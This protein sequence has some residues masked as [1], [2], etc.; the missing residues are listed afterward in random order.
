MENQVLNILT[1]IRPVPRCWAYYGDRRD[2]LLGMYFVGIGDLPPHDD[3]PYHSG[4]HNRLHHALLKIFRAFPWG[5]R[6]PRNHS[7][8]L[9]QRLKHLV[10]ELKTSSAFYLLLCTSSLPLPIYF[11]QWSRGRLA[12]KFFL[13]DQ[14]LLPYYIL[15]LIRSDIYF[16]NVNIMFI[17]SG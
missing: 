16:T 11:I 10:Q 13:W 12:L 4:V 6:C 17:I 5:I 8:H 15:E 1:L 3:L 7:G 14:L 2:N 9:I